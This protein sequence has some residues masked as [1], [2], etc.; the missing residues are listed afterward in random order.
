MTR[1]TWRASVRLAA[2][3]AAD[4]H[5]AQAQD[6]LH[7]VL[8]KHPKDPQALLL[9]A[10]VYVADGK[11]DEARRV[12]NLVITNEPNSPSAIQGYMLAGQIEAASDHIE[13]AITHYEHV[14][15]LQ[16]RPWA[17]NVALAR[18]YLSRGN[19]DK[20]ATYAQQA[21]AIQPANADAQSLMVRAAIVSGNLARAHDDLAGL[22][23]SFPDSI[24]VLKLTALVQLASKQLDA[25]HATYERVLH[26]APNDFEAL[27][28][29]VQI[30][31]AGGKGK[32][33]TARI[34]DRMKTATPSVDL[35]VLAARVHAATGDMPA[36]EGLLRKA[37]DTDPDRMPAYHM[38]GQL[39]ARTNRL[40]DAK[41]QYV[42]VLKRNP[43]L[44]LG[45]D[46][47]GDGARGAG[48]DPGG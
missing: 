17:A 9:S 14:L 37:I 46:D 47:G 26:A 35:L 16:P 39:Y 48:K 7:D 15:K 8:Q 3:D 18:L 41:A 12:V 13:E 33:A 42:G 45:S 24:G 28:G 34:D 21:L 20:A 5:H 11:R 32:Q 1:H 19:A 29:I 36:V 10:R 6:R 23:K 4:G 27:S 2:I 43:E 44:D 31:L 38:L 30:E 25:A 22:Q 40:E